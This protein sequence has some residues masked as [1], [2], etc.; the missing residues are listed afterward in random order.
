M[1]LGLKGETE[2]LIRAIA[3]KTGDHTY[4]VP[5]LD[6]STHAW[7][8]IEHDHH[9]IHAGSSFS[10]YYS[11]TT[12]ATDAHRSGI[13]LLTPD[14]AK[15]LH[16]VV[17]FSAS[18]AAFF[19]ICEGVTI[20]L[21]EGTNGVAIYNRDRNSTK[22][23]VAK[24]NATAHTANKV[25]TFTEAEIA[26]ANFAA[27]TIIRTEPLI[28]GGGPKPAGGSSRGAQEYILKKNTPYVFLLTNV[29][30]NANVHHILLDWYEHTPKGV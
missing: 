24:D 22:T 12:D 23:S 9:E 16:F 17:E 29:G 30:A 6:V 8:T 27:G 1:Y 15:E 13:Y 20:D 3:G 21:N 28:A 7:N 25:T 18:F 26:A 4:Q 14:T 2:R 19:S 11:R 10:A 5:R